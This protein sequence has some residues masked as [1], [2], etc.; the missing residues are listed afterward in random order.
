MLLVNENVCKAVPAD[1]A[2]GLRGF[3]LAMVLVVVV[4]AAIKGALA[5]RELD[6]DVTLTSISVIPISSPSNPF[7]DLGPPCQTSNL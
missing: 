3:G 5:R 2:A 1:M 4:E 7:L 6:Y